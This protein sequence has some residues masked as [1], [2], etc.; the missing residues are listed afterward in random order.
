M[1]TRPSRRPLTLLLAA[2]A[3]IAL[4]STACS[5]PDE[6]SS[7]SSALVP[8]PESGAFPVTIDQA[9]APVTIENAPTRVAA[10]GA[11][12]ADTLLAL[13]VTPVTIAPFAAP[14]QLKAP[15]NADLIGDA[16]PVVLNQTAQ[17]FGDEIPKALATNPDL[18]TAVGADPTRDQF[19]LLTKTAPTVMRPAQFEPWVVPWD[20]QTT[21]IGKAVGLPELAQRKI[22]ETNAYLAGIRDENP[23]LAG[24][25]AVVILNNPNGGVSIYGPEDGRGQVAASYGLSFPDSLRPLLTGGFYGE[26]PAESLNML[27]AVDVVIAVDWEGANDKLRANPAFNRLEV[28]R[29]GRVV[30]LPQDVGTAMSVP[31]LLTIP[32]VAERAVGPIAEAA[33]KS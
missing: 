26:L 17:S 2:V 14:D 9:Y 19:D 22:D 4:V 30:Y 29:S 27:D 13:G 33:A 21:Q 1:P 16:Q 20:A 18:I 31:N 7:E 5:S 8:A 25:T 23:Q 32:W 12:D 24:K 28:A 10:M 3:A 6:S 15:W 11:G